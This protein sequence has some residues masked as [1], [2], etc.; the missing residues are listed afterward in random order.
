MSSHYA[1]V[2]RLPR[3]ALVAGGSGLVGGELLTLLANDIRYGHVTSLG[4]RKLD[5]R[6]NVESRVVSFDNLDKTELPS[7]DDAFCC[8]GTTRRAAGSDEAFRDVDLHYVLAYARAAR[9]AGAMRFLLVSALG[10]NAQSR[11]LYTRV[12]GE[13]EAAVSALGYEVVGIVQPSFLTG[14]RAQSRLGETA[15][16]LLG[17][18]VS[19]L[20]AGPLHRFRPVKASAVA[21]ALISMA[22]N[23]RPGVTVLASEEIAAASTTISNQESGV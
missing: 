23:D 17:R 9:R 18:V 10:A 14:R 20:M 19:P 12:K 8:L 2:T 11:F 15:A 21:A 6:D 5:R 3:R 22:L 16:L 7:A 4:R 1:D 13:A